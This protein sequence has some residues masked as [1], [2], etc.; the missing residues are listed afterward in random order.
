MVHLLRD[1]VGKEALSFTV[2]ACS[3]L[4]R[5]TSTT[6]PPPTLTWHPSGRNCSHCTDT[7][8]STHSTFT[9]NHLSPSLSQLCQVWG[10]AQGDGNPRGGHQRADR[11][12]QRVRLELERLAGALQRGLPAE[13]IGSSPFAANPLTP[14]RRSPLSRPG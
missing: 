14:S 2:T 12:R 8:P 9:C 10:G 1:C 11:E 4:E 3:S 5:Q 6:T 7:V 13:H